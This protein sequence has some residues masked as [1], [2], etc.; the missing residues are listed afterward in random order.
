[1]NRKIFTYLKRRGLTDI[2]M[3]NRLFVSA[4]MRHHNLVPLNNTLLVEHYVGDLD[5]EATALTDLIAQLDKCECDYT[6]EELT[7]LFEFVISPSDR[8]I[9]G[10]I[11]TPGYIRERIVAEV[12]YGMQPNEIATKRFADIACGCGGFFLTIAQ[13]IHNQCG[14]SFA[15][16]YRENIFGIDIQ[17]YSIERTQLLLSLLALMNNEDVNFD[18][19]LN[20]ANTLSFDFGEIEPLDIIVGNPPYVCARNMSLETRDLIR[21]WDV[22]QSGNSDLYIPFFQIAIELLRDGGRLGYITMNSFLTSL[23][24]RALRDYFQNQSYQIHI[25]DFRGVQIFQGRNTYTCLF[26][27]EKNKADAVK[28]CL[29]ESRKLH[30]QFMYSSHPY[31]SLDAKG[32]WKLN[33]YYESRKKEYIGSSLGKYCQSRHGIATLSNKTYVFSPCRE[34]TD[35]YIFNRNNQDIEVEKTICRKIVNSNKL[36]SEITFEDIVEYVIFPYRQNEQGQMKLIPET[37]LM[38]DFPLAYSYLSSCREILAKRDKGDTKKYPAWY[39]YGRTQSL[40]M[41]RYKLFFPKIANKPLH[42]ILVDDANLLL[43][44]GMAFVSA[45]ENILLVLKRILESSLFW[46]YVTRNSKPYA[47]GYYSLNGV[48]IKNFGIPNFTHKQ[49]V[50]LLAMTTKNEINNWLKRFYE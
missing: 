39:A 11:Y 46:E 7:K 40:Q 4:F 15:D 28:Y 2:R 16:I 24:G 8:K 26:F 10:A 17:G 49:Q 30:S 19:H 20:Q 21:N 32:G 22:C 45:D 18:F 33:D 42:C 36:N 44:N 29:N 5:N 37:E 25:V 41:P 35:T 38:D 3:V 31:I 23:N 1:M 6:L 12:M 47:S 27:L 50:D 13:L 34:T 14:K 9:T 43:Y 48:N